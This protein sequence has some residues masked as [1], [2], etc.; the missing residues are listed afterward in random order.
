[1]DNG[2]NWGTIGRVGVIEVGDDREA[3][4]NNEVRLHG[5][6][7]P[8]RMADEKR[9]TKAWRNFEA[10]TCKHMRKRAGAPRWTIKLCKA[11]KKHQQWAES[12]GQG[13]R[14]LAHTMWKGILNCDTNGAVELKALHR[15]KVKKERKKAKKEKRQAKKGQGKSMGRGDDDDNST[16]SE[17]TSSSSLSSDTTSSGDTG[18][19]ATTSRGGS[20]AAG[21]R[22][23]EVEKGTGPTQ[24]SW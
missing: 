23:G 15:L 10:G 17:S 8:R 13:A 12:E 11:L 20:S 5:T 19:G 18:A 3:A 1:M 14:P 2:G 21:R 16:S 9:K 6:R 4:P 7:D 24:S 22:E